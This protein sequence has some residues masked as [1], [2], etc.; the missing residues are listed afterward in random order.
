MVTDPDQT[1]TGREEPSLREQVRN[2]LDFLECSHGMALR[3]KDAD[4]AHAYYQAIDMVEAA[5]DD[6]LRKPED[7]MHSELAEKDI[8]RSR[9]ARD[10]GF[11]AATLVDQRLPG[12]TEEPTTTL[13]KIRQ[14]LRGFFT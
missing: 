3:M 7:V 14:R 6:E 1:E 5:L 12:P 4:A 2:V 10:E 13:A 8:A 9:S 11:A